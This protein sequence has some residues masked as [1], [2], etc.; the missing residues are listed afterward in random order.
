[1][2]IG[3]WEIFM[4]IGILEKRELYYSKALKINP[5]NILIK[6]SIFNR[7]FRAGFFN[8]N[9]IND[10]NFFKFKDSV[11]VFEKVINELVSIDSLNVSLYRDI[12]DKYR[13]S[14][15]YL[16]RSLEYYLKGRY[17]RS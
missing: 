12:G 16:D 4:E 1:M 11:E 14:T 9:A 5:N 7:K 10:R 6:R 2:Y 13:Q 15:L 3:G 17:C 8:E